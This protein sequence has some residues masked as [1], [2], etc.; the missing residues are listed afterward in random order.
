MKE[1]MRQIQRDQKVLEEVD[2]Q[3]GLVTKEKS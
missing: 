1:L 3:L 2:I